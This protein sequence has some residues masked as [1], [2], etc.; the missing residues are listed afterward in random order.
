M[1]LFFA[2]Q[3]EWLQAADAQP[4]TLAFSIKKQNLRNNYLAEGFPRAMHGTH[5]ESEAGEAAGS[6]PLAPISGER[7]RVRGALGSSAAFVAG[8]TMPI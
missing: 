2:E 3:P 1:G 6:H 7:A 8:T 4:G 5:S